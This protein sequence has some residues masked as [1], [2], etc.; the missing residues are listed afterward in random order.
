MT[1]NQT[2]KHELDIHFPLLGKQMKENK[3][4]NLYQMQVSEQKESIFSY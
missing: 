4:M 3:K 1:P 2:P